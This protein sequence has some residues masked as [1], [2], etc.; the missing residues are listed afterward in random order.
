[1][2]KFLDNTFVTSQHLK[3]NLVNTDELLDME[4][5]DL[6][7]PLPQRRLREK[8]T[9]ARLGAE[10]PLSVEEEVA[11]NFA[12]ALCQQEKTSSEETLKLFELLKGVRKKPSRTRDAVSGGKTW[13]TGM[14]DF[15]RL[16]QG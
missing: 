5:R 15:G 13:T 14:L 6:E 7:Q 9:L 11:E 2:V 10:R 16:H 3:A 8:R 4:P 12:R 1:M